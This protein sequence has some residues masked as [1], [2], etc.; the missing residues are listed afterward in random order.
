M[1]PA[2]AASVCG[3]ES[4][5]VRFGRTRIATSDDGERQQ[6]EGDRRLGSGREVGGVVGE[7]RSWDQAEEAE[8]I[9]EQQRR[10]RQQDPLQR[11]RDRA[12]RLPRV[13][14]AVAHPDVEGGDQRRQHE[15]DR[16][17][18]EGP[19]GDDVVAEP[20]VLL[21]P[22]RR[23]PRRS[24]PGSAAARA[25]C[26]PP[27]ES[28]SVETRAPFASPGV[29]GRSPEPLT[30]IASTPSSASAAASPIPIGIAS[31]DSAAQPPEGAASS[32]NC[33]VAIESAVSKST[34]G[35]ESGPAWPVKTKG[36]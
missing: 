24:R 32:P 25:R 2:A 23:C 12:P 31:R 22:L 21:R 4:S 20:H 15:R 9:G 18:R 6:R 8:Q 17:Q 36:W 29:G 7:V 34:A 1:I 28:V 11:P 35:T 27:S 3:S 13:A 19:A 16:E 30:A 14:A 5:G 33:V 26:C 10:Q